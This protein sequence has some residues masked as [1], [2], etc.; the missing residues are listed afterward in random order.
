MLYL[1]HPLV[2]VNLLFLLNV[3]VLFWIISIISGSTWLIDAAWTLLPPLM[4]AVY[5]THP[6]A[7]LTAKAAVAHCLLAA[8][9]VRLTHSYFRRQQINVSC[10]ECWQ[11]GAREDWRFAD[12]RVRLGQ[13]RFRWMS[14]FLTYV[15]QHLMLLGLTLPFYSI[16]QNRTTWSLLDT[17]GPL[18]CCAAGISVAAAADTQLHKFCSANARLP[19]TERKLVLDTGLWRYARHPNHFGEQAWWWGVALLAEP[20]TLIGPLFNTLCMLPV[21]FLVEQRMLA[22]PERR[23]AYTQYMQQTSCLIPWPPLSRGA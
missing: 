15:S 20:W 6:H 3:D 16:S 10:R 11:L 13:Y 12:M 17:V 2:Y 21:T 18:Q 9:S 19:A 4:A 1:E 14:F 8:W 7:V 23:Y 5:S 22:R